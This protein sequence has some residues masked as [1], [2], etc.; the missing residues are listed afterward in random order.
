MC[1]CTR[2][3]S[4]YHKCALFRHF[5]SFPYIQ[6]V[7]SG[8][9]RDFQSQWQCGVKIGNGLPL[10]P[11]QYNLQ[12][13]L[14]LIAISGDCGIT[15]FSTVAIFM[16]LDTIDT[17]LF[18]PVLRGG[19]RDRRLTINFEHWVEIFCVPTCFHMRIPNPCLSVCPS[20]CRSVCLSAPR[21]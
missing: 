15:F 1:I 11:F 5:L 13:F 7:V 18:I 17:L 8:E 14:Y 3:L 21:E 20:V 12:M 4:R 6:W 2:A 19:N 10:I 16:T 9:Q